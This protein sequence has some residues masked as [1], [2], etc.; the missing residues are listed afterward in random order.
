MDKLGYTFGTNERQC[1]LR[2]KFYIVKEEN[3]LVTKLFYEFDASDIFNAQENRVKIN[4][5]YNNIIN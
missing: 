5:H 3:Y 2:Q 4:V 1:K